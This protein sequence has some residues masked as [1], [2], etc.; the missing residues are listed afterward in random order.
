MALKS[1]TGY[2]EGSATGGGFRIMVELSSVN[3][4][5][6]DIQIALPRALQAVE[7]GMHTLIRECF[8]R[9]RIHGSVRVES[10]KGSA[11]RVVVDQPLAS[12]YVEALEQLSKTL[13][14]CEPIQLETLARMPEVLRVEAAL[15][16]SDELGLLF[17]RA[18][19][20]A[21][22]A[23]K[24]MRSAEGHE[25]EL[26]L[27]TRID[28]L[29]AM[30]KDLIERAPELTVVYRTRLLERL[31]EQ[32][33]DEWAK[34][35]RII[36]EVAL[37]ADR[38]DITEELIRLRSH[39]KQ[40]LRHSR[41][42]EPAGRPLDFLCQEVFREINTI[43][44]KASDSLITQTVVQFKTELERIREQIQNVE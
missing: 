44:S 10:I 5:Q 4:K 16:A 20:K 22:K 30:R 37:F 11:T 19:E 17:T 9:G 28:Q 13:G 35:E 6:L 29:E 36:R 7:S 2:G 15:P 41:S 12:S 3:R 18:M 26:D 1:M 24:K 34:D 14:S 38:S 43:G 40:M 33:L 8:S 25:L 39:L 32:G 23:L 42:R 27:R 21:L 31:A